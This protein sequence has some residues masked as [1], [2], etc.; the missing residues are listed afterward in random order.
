MTGPRFSYRK[1]DRVTLFA[2]A[3]AGARY[4]RTSITL[5]E[6][7]GTFKISR[8]SFAV[9]TGGGVDVKVTKNFGIR[10]F[11]MDYIHSGHPFALDRNDLRLSSGVVFRFGK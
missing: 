2:H 9:G 4:D 11:Q 8:T 7:P 3:L 1:I 10:A 6:P 5:G